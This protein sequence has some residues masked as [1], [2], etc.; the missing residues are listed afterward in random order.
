LK[1]PDVHRR[2]LEQM[3]DMSGKKK[4][5]SERERLDRIGLGLVRACAENRDEAEAAAASPFLYARLRS[6]IETERKQ[7]EEGEGW[8][9]MLAVI[10]RAVPAL[11][12]VSIFTVALFLSSNFGASSQVAFNDDAL[13]G[14]N[15]A[16]VESVVF[17]DNRALSSD[18]VLATILD[19]DSQEASR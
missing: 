12:L 17:A 16:G 9:A 7:R 8:L 5:L 15:E 13:L 11:A 14:A 4:S 2:P 1:P 19:E 6:R 18:D 3:K 10:W